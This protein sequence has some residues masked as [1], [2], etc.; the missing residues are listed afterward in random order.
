MRGPKFT[1]ARIRFD[2]SCAD[3]VN[4]R[5]GGTR[6]DCWEKAADR[7]QRGEGGGERERDNLAT[8]CMQSSCKERIESNRSIT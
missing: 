4:A 7:S 8:S 1:E 6:L 2:D 5:K 3:A